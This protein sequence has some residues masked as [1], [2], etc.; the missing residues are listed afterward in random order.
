MKPFSEALKKKNTDTEPVEDVVPFVEPVKG[1]RKFFIMSS[2]G[3][4][5]DVA[6]QLQEE[7]EEVLLYIPEKEYKTIGD[8]IVPK[9]ENFHEYLGKGYVFVVDGCEHAKLQD[10]MR[11]K[12]EHV[13]G[14]NEVMVGYEEDRQK[15]Q[16]LFKKCGFHVP[17]SENFTD[18]D[19][20]IDFIEENEGTRFV[21]KQ[22]G[23]APKSLNHMGKFE[24]GSDMIYHLEELKKSWKESTN[25]EVNFD[26]MEI[27]EGV[28]LAASAFFNGTDW[29]RDKD[30]QVVGFI[31]Q[32]YKKQLDGDLGATTG[33]MGTLFIGVDETNEA[34]KTMILNPE[35]IHLLKKSGYRG[36]F[37]INGSW[38]EKG[39]VGFE[40]TSRFGIPAT[41]YEFMEGLE[42]KTGDIL[43]YMACG[44]DK[45]ISI[46]MGIGMVTVVVSNPFPIEADM[47]DE[48]TSLGQKLWILKDKSPIS[49]FT[50]EQKKHI[51]LENFKK[52]GDGYKV[53]TKGGYL[54][55]VTMT[56]RDIEDVREKSKEY[57][58]DN[59]HISG[60]GY[61]QDLGKNLEEHLLRFVPK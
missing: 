28:E 12:G 52:D 6:I 13:V 18:F 17:D 25:G 14:T 46:H 26:L 49:E 58:K 21:L 59:I 45:P 4:I 31:N 32:E 61:R 10:W 57:I 38:T 36:V 23:D 19:D 35:I 2:F 24:D 40:P 3:E 43:E 60:M 48:A 44:F 47:D 41:S 20:A 16:E 33:E 56:G 55:T 11:S 39:F 29:L 9:A 8:G 53:A 7:G 37:D 54:L 22:N 1:K 34:F 50:K 27:V 30:G 15:G 5:L 51:H 42:M